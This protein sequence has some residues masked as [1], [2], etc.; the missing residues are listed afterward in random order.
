MT[1]FND[2]CIDANTS[3]LLERSATTIS[4]ADKDKLTRL[5][6][7]LTKPKLIKLLKN[8]DG[9]VAQSDTKSIVIKALI[10]RRV[11][12]PVKKRPRP[13]DDDADR[14]PKTSRTTDPDLL[15]LSEVLNSDEDSDTDGKF[16]PGLSPGKPTLHTHNSKAYEMI[17]KRT[18]VW[19]Y[20]PKSTM[21]VIHYGII[22]LT[23][24]T[25]GLMFERDPFEEQ[26]VKVAGG[27]TLN[28][29]TMMRFFFPLPWLL[30]LYRYLSLIA[31]VHKPMTQ[32]VFDYFMTFLQW[33]YENR[34]PFARIVEYERRLRLQNLGN[35]NKADW[36]TTDFNLLTNFL[37]VETSTNYSRSSSSS[38][39][40]SS[41]DQVSGGQNSGASS[42]KK[43][44]CF[45]WRDRTCKF[46]DACRFRHSCDHCK[47]TKVHV[48]E[49]CPHW[50]KTQGKK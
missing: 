19:G 41:S 45:K 30:G 27:L 48:K 50:L 49:V 12:F 3:I 22:N 2:K 23:F 29:K 10:E 40:S 47:A 28:K 1:S 34:Y 43:S 13:D 44:I 39:S 16:D 6:M 9:D 36:P 24:I 25:L 4:D 42:G 26:T 11:L 7:T 35:P 33:C 31:A 21:K 32:A 38:S 5:W 37:L 20:F 14:V 17:S 15:A 8:N 18:R 46:G